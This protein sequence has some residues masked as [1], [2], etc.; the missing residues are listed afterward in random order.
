M[1]SSGGGNQR[2]CVSRNC[3]I[4]I[5]PAPQQVLHHFVVSMTRSL[6]QCR[7]VTRNYSVRIGPV[8]Q[9]VINHG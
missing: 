4:N 2:I 6:D 7:A 9:Q 8:L 3:H 1:T 5:G